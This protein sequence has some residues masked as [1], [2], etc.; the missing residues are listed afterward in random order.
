MD[1]NDITKTGKQSYIELQ[2][3]NTRKY[4]AKDYLGAYVGSMV[5]PLDPQDMET[6]YF[7]SE[8]K[9]GVGY[10][11]FDEQQYT[12][13][14]V[15]YG[16]LENVRAYNQP[17]ALKWIN[18][19]GKMAVL[20][21]T[22]FL[23]GIGGLITGIGQGILNLTDDDE[24]TGFLQGLWDNPFS[25]AMQDIQN[26]ADELMPNYRTRA[27]QNRPW[28]QNLGTANFW[29]DTI[30]KNLGF[31]IG[32]ASGAGL[33]TKAVTV[34][35]RL[36]KWVTAV[37]RSSRAEG[38]TNTVV[39]NSLM[40]LNEGRVEALH[41][42]T[43]WAKTYEE[44][45]NSMRDV[46]IA[47]AEA[48]YGKDT[49][50]YLKEVGK[51][52]E[53]YKKGLE[54][55]EKNR[56]EMGNATMGLN[57]PVLMLNNMFMYSKL[58]SGGANTLRRSMQ[59][60]VKVS[61]AK[62]GEDAVASA[63]KAL[64]D[65][66]ENA[67]KAE[68]RS[69]KK[70]L[71]QAEKEAKQASKGSSG[72]ILD[73]QGHIGQYVHNPRG[74]MYGIG[75][76]LSHGASE[77]AEEL[78][79]RMIAEGTG[80][81]HGFDVMESYKAGKD[82]KYK[83]QAA[84]LWKA[85]VAGWDKSFGDPQAYEEFFVGAITGLLGIPQFRSRT[86][87]EQ[88]VNP[89]T[90]ELE[91]VEKKRS[92]IYL[93]G[94]LQEVMQDL[95][96]QN[97][98]E[99]DIV[100]YLNDRIQNPKFQT[101]L[102][103]LAANL[104][105]GQSLEEAI[106]KNDLF[107]FKN[108][109]FQQ[110]I[111]DIT[112][113]SQAGR[114]QDYKDL[115]N[116]LLDPSKANIKSIVEQTS[117]IVENSEKDEIIGEFSEQA[118]I[119]NTEDLQQDNNNPSSA[120]TNPQKTKRVQFVDTPENVEAVQSK[121]KRKRDKLIELADLIENTRRDID[122]K[123]G[124]RF[125]SEELSLLTNLRVTSLNHQE[126]ARTLIR[127]NRNTL[128]QILNNL[129]PN[130]RDKLVSLIHNTS[131]FTLSN[132]TQ[133]RIDPRLKREETKN[134]KD[135]LLSL[136]SNPEIN[137]SDRQVDSILGL[138]MNN[139]AF[140]D[141][142]GQAIVNQQIQSTEEINTVNNL[143]KSLDDA[144]A[145]KDWSNKYN[146]ALSNFLNKPD[147]LQKAMDKA[148]K[149]LYDQYMQGRVDEYYEAISQAKDIH[150]LRDIKSK[151]S[152][153]ATLVGKTYEKAKKEGNDRLV[154]LMEDE[155]ELTAFAKSFA[156]NFS[157]QAGTLT[158]DEKSQ[159]EDLIDYISNTASTAQEVR[160]VLD[161]IEKNGE[162]TIL[163]DTV[164]PDTMESDVEEEKREVSENIQKQIAKLNKELK[165]TK[166]FSSTE[167]QESRDITEEEIDEDDLDK[168][169]S[170]DGIDENP[171]KKKRKN[172]RS[173]D[174][175]LGDPK[176]GLSSAISHLTD[177]IKDGILN[178]ILNGE[179]DQ[180]LKD[181][182][183]T[184]DQIE[185]IKKEA[186]HYKDLQDS[187]V[188]NGNTRNSS[189][190][191]KSSADT[192]TSS[193]QE[194]SEYD[195][196]ALQ[197]PETRTLKENKNDKV[198][199]LRQLGVFE[200]INKGYLGKLL[201][202]ISYKSDGLPIH[203][204]K[205]IQGENGALA[206][207]ILLAVE[208]NDLFKL[209]KIKPVHAVEIGGKKYQ[210]VGVLSPSSTEESK[211]SYEN[212]KNLVEQEYENQES[213]DKQP[214]ISKHTNRIKRI[215]SGRFAT[216]S[217]SQKKE[218]RSLQ[219]ILPNQKYEDSQDYILGFRDQTGQIQLVGDTHN[220]KEQLVPPNDYGEG[221]AGGRFL[222]SRQADGL[223]YPISLSTRRLSVEYLSKNQ[224][225]EIVKEIKSLLET[226][227]KS[228]DE[229]KVLEA[230]RKLETILVMQGNPNAIWIKMKGKNKIISYKS[231]GAQTSN[232][233]SG[234]NNNEIVDKLFEAIVNDEYLFQIHKNATAE[235][236]NKLVQ[237]GC[238]ITDSISIHNFNGNFHVHGVDSNGNIINPLEEVQTWGDIYKPK[239][240][241]ITSKKS[242]FIQMPAETSYTEFHYDESKPV[243]Q[244]W[245]IGKSQFHLE[246]DKQIEL[247]NYYRVAQELESRKV[248][249]IV[250]A[251]NSFAVKRG[252]TPNS[253]IIITDPNE[254]DE[255]NRKKKKEE[256]NKENKNKD[257]NKEKEE[258]GKEPEAKPKD[259]NVGEINNDGFDSS[260]PNRT[261]TRRR[262]RKDAN[263]DSPM[264]E[265]QKRNAADQQHCK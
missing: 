110:L 52:R 16:N 194:T 202:G 195:L 169:D 197:N 126:R 12:T 56:I 3:E 51:I 158:A 87:R 30:I 99:A 72:P 180:T 161:S 230:K 118:E 39:G 185:E 46:Q 207:E 142:F 60:R 155:D 251:T 132:E 262:S 258:K 244:R 107:N 199:S 116:H 41:N 106:K 238:L 102:E 204:I 261:R 196:G 13:G 96:V 21:G 210:I 164:N 192:M 105:D 88:Q 26:L 86:Y 125:T 249:F 29:A 225:S 73:V 91:M 65:L 69:A 265:E 22:T 111:R 135:D 137:L 141:Y 235:H 98:R 138:F 209:L 240:V 94:G 226:I 212:V 188:K 243:G 109:E 170:N 186:Q 217:E 149:E 136:L 113:F 50:E 250:D 160:D 48:K 43:E 220:L 67:T 145:N 150:H 223:L 143:I 121:L 77:G 11:A 101:Q 128:A 122:N 45:L 82:P 222:F 252:S 37:T 119:I 255:L 140:T 232:I 133:S 95:K 76:W 34:G 214:I 71:K 134:E 176:E 35:G 242:I 239:T 31:A 47:Q 70:A 183:W 184:E 64:D 227:V 200:F 83:K 179:L 17:T 259:D 74:T 10:S 198:T 80:Q 2:R 38:L 178:K 201:R 54:A 23:D 224:D 234:S 175:P 257:K 79:Q 127:E 154:K 144:L 215:Y 58:F 193:T 246:P 256:K 241:N 253:Y 1:T 103:N 66:G 156:K 152:E 115:I 85:T 191:I 6:Q 124:G 233:I 129:S 63:K 174:K 59:G 181:N 5:T 206:D 32:A 131:G 81:Y 177:Q 208:V 55:L 90:G 15:Y 14:D 236:I 231:M 213:Q 216:S 162:Y 112:M 93:A 205:G 237:S 75:K 42:A 36:G 219:Q 114:L 53:G 228:S 9:G 221:Y 57:V 190:H 120:S 130:D 19:V 254:I 189:E 146:Q 260:K 100:K 61:T 84:D 165:R 117:S 211:Q 108:K 147:K 4:T 7:D 20:A 68:I 104:Q 264:T 18:G 49:P 157:I 33:L 263:L 171:E 27:E 167:G 173:D 62:Q 151:F 203:Y 92:P 229:T 159:I 24:N 247:D 78:S 182:G 168:Y 97:Q 139:S 148:D 40:A 248:D 44:E 25:R 89:E 172:E 123:T 187:K 28:W 166:K 218:Q 153:S 8:I 245:S 163:R